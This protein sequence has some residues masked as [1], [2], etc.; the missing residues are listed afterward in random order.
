V[1][2]CVNGELA[3]GALG[4]RTP[5]RRRELLQERDEETRKLVDRKIVAQNGVCALCNEPSTDYNDI[6]PDHKNPRGMGGAWRDDHPGP[7]L[8]RPLVV[9]R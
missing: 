8:D 7:N 5:R 1:E 3:F 2:K 4:S 9:Q 6:L